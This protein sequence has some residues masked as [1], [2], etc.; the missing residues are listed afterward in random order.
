VGTL[1]AA[2]N[3]ARSSA[4]LRVDGHN[5]VP[6]AST[7]GGDLVLSWDP[8]PTTVA[9]GLR[10]KDGAVTQL[11]SFPQQNS[12]GPAVVA[13]DG[14]HVVVTNS[15]DAFSPPNDIVLF[16]VAAK[17]PLHLL[18]AAPV[19]AG[20]VVGSDVALQDGYVYWGMTPP[21]D[22]SHGMVIR[23]SIA[24]DSYR[25]LAR[26]DR[27]P[28]VVSDTRGVAWPGGAVYR[29]GL[30]SAL[31]PLLDQTGDPVDRLVTDGRT[32]AW[33]MIKGDQTVFHWADSSGATRTF[34]LSLG[35][36]HDGAGVTAVSGPFLFFHVNW[37][38]DTESV[39][40]TR[41]GALAPARPDETVWS[42]PG[43]LL[44][45]MAGGSEY[46]EINTSALSGFDCN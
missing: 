23:Y 39:L 44:F 38:S 4:P 41:T 25:V 8:T 43:R 32:Y 19:P 14:K 1:P 21:N 22:D 18:D 26:P 7:P 24:K 46:H 6:H 17:S 9:I 45:A 37:S 36:G 27:D 30:P 35:E 10:A 40:D 2:W 29:K 12:G 16:D 34:R 13:T 11:G 20:W 33:Q 5:A 15:P 31:N 28:R 3:S 42:Y